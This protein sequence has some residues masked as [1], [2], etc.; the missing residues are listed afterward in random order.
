MKRQFAF[1]VCDDFVE[2]IKHFSIIDLEFAGIK[3]K[4]NNIYIVSISCSIK[5]DDYDNSIVTLN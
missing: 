3:K 2:I 1:S 5:L 4:K